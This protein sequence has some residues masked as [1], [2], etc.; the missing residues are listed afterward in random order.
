MTYLAWAVLYE[1]S[2]DKQYFDVLIPRIMDELVLNRGTRHA[3]VP[4]Q[5]VM[6]FRR[7]S[8]ESVA[9]EICENREAYHLVFIHADTGGRALEQGLAERSA[10]FC[11]AANKLCNWPP[12]RCILITPRHE[13]EA[14]AMADG[15]AV[16][17]ALGYRGT[18]ASIGLPA[19]PA[20]AERLADPKSALTEAVKRVRSSR[21]PIDT[22]QLLPT[23]AQR[24]SL[25]EL[26]R[27]AHFRSLE[28]AISRALVSLGAIR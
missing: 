4:L 14:W 23:I 18:P 21:R 24:Q 17:D 16:C 13:L 12:E 2:D 9:I 7:G 20:A 10:A 3:T 26:R 6:D 11:D 19:S 28:D 25:V 1:G 22:S 15:S 27:L 8:T 5:P